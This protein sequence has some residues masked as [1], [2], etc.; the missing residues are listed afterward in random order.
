[1][2]ATQKTYPVTLKKAPFDQRDQKYRYSKVRAAIDLPFSFDCRADMRPIKD[3]GNSSE[4]AAFAKASSKEYQEI[5]DPGIDFNEDL[6][7]QYLYDW[8]AGK[9]DPGMDLRDLAKIV[10]NKGI[11][12]LKDY[13]FNGRDDNPDPS[14]KDVENGV[15]HK[16]DGYSRVQTVD[17]MRQAIFE[18]GPLTIGLPVYNFGPAFWRKGP[19]EYLLGGHGVDLVKYD[20]SVQKCILRNSWGSSWYG[21]EVEFQYEDM[22]LV[23]DSYQDIDSDS[24]PSPDPAPVQWLQKIWNWIVNLWRRIFREE[25]RKHIRK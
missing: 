4:C 15:K 13:P 12:T 20:D 25:Y 19:G 1:M 21:G 18:N 6:S 3:Q 9:P 24:L 14:A 8:R 16:S 22:A 23:W 7:P 11:A 2:E 5:V 17:E 10:C